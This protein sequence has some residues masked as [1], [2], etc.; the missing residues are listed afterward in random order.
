M[1]VNESCSDFASGI[2]SNVFKENS[3]L[4]GPVTVKIVKE[5]RTEDIHL[6]RSTIIF[7]ENDSMTGAILKKVRM[8]NIYIMRFQHHAVIQKVIGLIIDPGLRDVAEF[9]ITHYT[10]FLFQ[11]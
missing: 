4:I 9:D 10:N 5:S 3:H 1:I 11:D 6:K 8:S 2:I 7:I